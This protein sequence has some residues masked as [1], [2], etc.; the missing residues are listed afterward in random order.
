[1]YDACLPTSVN[2]RLEVGYFWDRHRLDIMMRVD[3]F[4][5]LVLK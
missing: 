4:D 3:F 2:R 5:A 1:M